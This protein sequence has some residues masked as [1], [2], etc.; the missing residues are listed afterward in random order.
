VWYHD[1]EPGSSAAGRVL[2]TNSEAASLL[3]RLMQR[4]SEEFHAR[5]LFLVRFARRAYHVCWRI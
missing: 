5:V 2:L 1:V 3:T 4:C